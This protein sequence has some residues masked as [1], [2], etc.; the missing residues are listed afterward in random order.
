MDPADKMIVALDYASWPEAEELVKALPNVRFFKVGL[1]LYLGSSGLAVPKLKEMGKEVFLD[2]KFHD[3]PHTVA[4]AARR[5]VSQGVSIFNLHAAG[6]REMMVKAAQATCEQADILKVKKPLLLAVTVLTSLN[7][8]DL[9]EIGLGR[10]AETVAT[11]AG[12]AQ[13]A[14]LDGVVASPWEIKMIRETCGPDFT[15]ICPGVRPVWSASGDQKRILTPG[16]A[17][18][19]GADYLVIG[20]PITRSGDPPEAAAKILHEIETAGL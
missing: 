17:I 8:Q 7:E 10:V 14:G 15:I 6:G 2:L 9:S 19:Q 4:Q 12:M 13:K 1:E 16:E 3:I 11:W 5:A 18:S 20:R